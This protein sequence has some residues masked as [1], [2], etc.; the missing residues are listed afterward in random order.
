MSVEDKI[1]VDI[2]IGDINGLKRNNSEN[3]EDSFYLE[4]CTCYF[5]FGEVDVFLQ[6]HYEIDINFHG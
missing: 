2:S 4:F 6:K 3:I 1:V 5:C